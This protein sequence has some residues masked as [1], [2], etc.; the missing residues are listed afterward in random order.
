MA[1][2]VTVTWSWQ[3]VG[4]LKLVEGKLAFPKVPNV[5]GVYRL[6]LLDAA[7]NRTGVCVGEAARFQ[8]R[9]QN[10]QTPGPSQATNLRMNSILSDTLRQGGTVRV[11]I[12]TEA[13]AK[14][15]EEPLPSLGLTQKARRRLVERAAEVI[16]R[17]SGAPELN[18]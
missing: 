2:S 11:E 17:E 8:P 10:Y 3:P 18:R 14:I 6:T 5:A 9:F 7:G 15:G 1:Q 13:Q 12:I 16:E 4:Q